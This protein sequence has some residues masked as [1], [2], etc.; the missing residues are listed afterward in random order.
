MH[1]RSMPVRTGGSF[2]GIDAS[3]QPLNKVFGSVSRCPS[4]PRCI[5]GKQ[6]EWCVTAAAAV[7]PR[8]SRL[9]SQAASGASRKTPW[10]SST[11]PPDGHIR[12]RSQ[13]ETQTR[14]SPS[15]PSLP[16]FYSPML[17]PDMSIRRRSQHE[18]QTRSGPS[19]PSLPGFY[20]PML[21]P[22]VSIRRRSQHETQTRSGPSAPSLPGF[23]SPMLPPDV[24]IR[25]L[26]LC[27]AQMCPSAQNWLGVVGRTIRTN[28]QTDN[29]PIR[30]RTTRPARPGAR[31]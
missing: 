5:V 21:P 8:M 18:T 19:A 15:A 2:A 1:G 24:S 10:S 25:R 20:S 16:G 17:P 27:L 9:Q 6:C 7:T 23:Y 22:D 14:S 4:P 30:P 28:T 31:P 11:L 13:H 29:I 12:R 3:L 26:A